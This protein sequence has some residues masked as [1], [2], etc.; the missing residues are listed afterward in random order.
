MRAPQK[1]RKGSTP[2]LQGARPYADVAEALFSLTGNSLG[3]PAE[4]GA[5]L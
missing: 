1:K 2:F 3:L 5:H 4:R